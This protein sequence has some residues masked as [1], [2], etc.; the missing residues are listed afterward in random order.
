MLEKL[1]LNNTHNTNNNIETKRL[2]IEN[3]VKVKYS[4]YN[5]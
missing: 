2:L 4:I 1:F 5:N 3:K